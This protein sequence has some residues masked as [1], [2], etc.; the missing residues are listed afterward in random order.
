MQDRPALRRCAGGSPAEFAELHW[1][2][3]PLLS[4]AEQLPRDFADLFSVAAADELLSRRG[5]RTPFIRLAKNGA[6]VDTARYT[7]GGGVGAQVADQVADD[8]VLELFLDGH[9]IV[10]QGLHRLWPP[11]IE[12][13]G[14][15]GTDLGH[16]VQVNAYITPRSSTG[17]AAHY[18]V[19]DVFVLQISG[20]KRWRIHEPVH[21]DP[22][23]TQPWEQRK[24]AV[25]A[26]AGGTPALEAVLRPGDALYLPR[27]YLHAAEA[28]HGVSVHLTVGV[29]PVTRHD[30]VEVLSAL[31]SDD[32]ELRRSLPLGINASDPKDIDED[33]A[34]TVEAL[35]TRLRAVRSEDVSERLGARVVA[36]SRPAPLSPLAQADA[37]EHVGPR[38]V[39]A[40]RAHLRHTIIDAGQQLR[41]RLPNRQVVLPLSAR[42]ALTALFAGAVLRVDELPGLDRDEALVLA[43]RL[44]RDGVVVALD[45]QDDAP[46]G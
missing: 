25:Q 36:G 16:P 46:D 20:E 5:L 31:V 2:R 13:A 22:L 1:G 28:L 11:I 3:R 17:F 35:I 15:L 37:L 14:A 41:L 8:R 43:R 45:A 38:T 29:H 42:H 26:Q 39:V 9:S 32:A 27:G 23:R 7:G 10:L 24:A 44:L 4:P 33:V 18:D 12:F 6:I 21:L 30:I 40:A 34:A 19:H